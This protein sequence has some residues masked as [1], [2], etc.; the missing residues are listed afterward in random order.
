MKVIDIYISYSN[1]DNKYKNALLGQLKTLELQGL[2]RLFMSDY[3]PERV[4]MVKDLPSLRNSKIIILLIS[5]NYLS[6]EFI[7]KNELPIIFDKSKPNDKLVFSILIDSCS[8]TS[9]PEL[10]RIQFLNDV[11]NPLLKTYK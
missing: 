8:W 6:E 3:N 9:I 5:S 2:S 1:K 4:N 11:R 10:V 7:M